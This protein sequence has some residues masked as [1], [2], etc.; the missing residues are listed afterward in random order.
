MVY[1]NNLAAVH[2]GKGD[3]DLAVETANKAIEVG[4]EF[5]AAFTDLAKGY[6][7]LANSLVKLGKLEEAIVAFDKSLME[8]KDPQVVLPSLHLGSAPQLAR[9]VSLHALCSL[10]SD[11]A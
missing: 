4:R 11:L 2:F 8:N 5:R 3:Y 10:P 7:R 6:A 1:V 9:Q